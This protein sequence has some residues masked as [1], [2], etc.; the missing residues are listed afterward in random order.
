V[1]ASFNLGNLAGREV[2]M[3]RSAHILRTTAVQKKV[4]SLLKQH[5]QRAHATMEP[6]SP[7]IMLST[8]IA[9]PLQNQAV[10]S[11]ANVSVVECRRQV[12]WREQ[13]S[14]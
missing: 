12:N 4:S 11:R 7:R 9:V 14:D 2:S 6:I 8:C 13:C 3:I 10:T 1:F 5:E